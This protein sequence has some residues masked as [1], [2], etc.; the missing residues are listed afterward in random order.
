MPDFYCDTSQ[1]G[2]LFVHFWEKIVGSGHASFA[3]RA[4]WQQ[5]LKKCHEELGFQTVRFHGLFSNPIGP[6]SLQGEKVRYSFFN[7]DRIY[8]FLLSIGVRPFVELGFMPEPLASGKKTVFNYADNITPPKDYRLWQ[9]LVHELVSHCVDRYGL[10]E[11]QGWYFEVW[12]EPNLQDFWIATLD[13]YFKLYRVSAEAIKSVDPGIRVGGPA[14]SKNR[15]IEPFLSFC[16]RN[17]VPADFVT[18]HHYP[19]DGFGNEDDETEVKLSKSKRSVLRMQAQDVRRQVQDKPLFYTEWNTS[20]NAIERRHDEPYAAAFV[21]KTIMEAHG[22]VDGYSFWTFTDIF[23]E[24]YFPSQPFHGGFGLLNLYGIPKPT[25]RAFQLLHYLGDR[26]LLVDGLHN[27]VDA[28]IVKGKDKIDVLLTNH[29]LPRHDI[30]TERVE[31]HL[32]QARP[33]ENVTLARIDDDHANPRRAWLALGEPEYLQDR[34]LAVL[35]EASQLEWQPLAYEQQDGR[36][37]LSLSLPPHAVALIRLQYKEG[38]ETT[39][40]E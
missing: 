6:V 37:D 35:D 3:L 12:N 36:L 13:E 22:I 19:D 30:T 24:F 26:R 27:T 8:D 5:Q 7:I 14:S 29:A 4:D 25:Y 31:I 15:L 10:E 39:R 16:A 2:Q 1:R 34:E 38:D 20:S 32:E 23:N 40:N 9:E 33:P 21:A 18:T 11:V 17:D 28:W